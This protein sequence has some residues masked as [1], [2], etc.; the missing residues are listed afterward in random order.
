MGIAAKK[1]KNPFKFTWL[2]LIALVYYVGVRIFGRYY[3]KYC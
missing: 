1:C 2:V 3:F